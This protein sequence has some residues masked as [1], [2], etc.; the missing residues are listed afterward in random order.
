MNWSAASRETGVGYTRILG[1]LRRLGI[2]GICRQTVHNILKEEGIDTS[3]KRSQGTWE[4][5][6]QIHAKTLWACDFFS[7][8]VITPRGIFEYFVLVFI[9]METREIFVT[10]A[11]A[12]PKAE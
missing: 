8:K 9:K 2:N 6:I 3:P 11:T 7:K 12:H 1:E 4:Q 10:N 5:F